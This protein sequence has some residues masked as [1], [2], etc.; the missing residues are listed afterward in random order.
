MRT[1]YQNKIL[2]VDNESGIRDL[3]VDVLEGSPYR[4][5]TYEDGL[6]AVEA[7]KKNHYDM[8]ITDV[9]MPGMDGLELIEKAK[10]INPDI[11]AIV[12]TGFATL[13]TARMAIRKGACDYLLKPFNIVEIEL[14]VKNAFIRKELN[15]ENN[16]LRD[17]TGLFS[18]SKAINSSIANS[19]DIYETILRA[20]MEQTFAA[21]GSLV[22]IKD[23]S[24][25]EFEFVKSA[26][27]SKKEVREFN[28]LVKTKKFAS[29]ALSQ[30]D[31][32]FMGCYGD[33]GE[34]PS[35]AAIKKTSEF[36]SEAYF[37]KK[38]DYVFIPIKVNRKILGF[39]LMN[40]KDDSFHP[41][42]IQVLTIL[43]NQAAVAIE[44]SRLLKQLRQ[45]YL[46]MFQ[47]LIVVLE[48][49]DPY[50]SGH[51]ER[52]TALSLK[53]GSAMGLEKKDLDVLSTAAR[54]HDIGKVGISELVLNK[55]GKLS[56]EER[57]IIEEHPVIGDQ[58]L[59]PIK[60]F[61]QVRKI[62]R[63]HH[64]QPDG[65]GY[66]DGLTAKDL[67]VFMNIV[68]VADAFDAMNSDRSYRKSLSGKKILNELLK[69]KGSQFDVR[70]VNVLMDLVK[71]GDIKANKN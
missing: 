37:K 6:Q 10:K 47:S 70:V 43:S 60:H 7:L 17:L 21:S 32:V 61:E 57:K 16:R 8:L 5:E 35:R 44:N 64:E 67:S 1:T 71:K 51:T 54:V 3:V 68:H 39:F 4:L 9:K 12:M 50:T 49:K 30:S 63:H 11:L 42:E 69:Y 65:K 31:P 29:F 15:D 66:P 33:Q 45:A 38:F 36:R 14:S 34:G 40:K 58:I 48:A 24:S 19:A 26:Q 22:I 46:N 28:Q 55:I 27:L 53:I 23:E 56:L 52:V 25:E 62:V 18:V 2:I 41:S 13:D 59:R 20:S